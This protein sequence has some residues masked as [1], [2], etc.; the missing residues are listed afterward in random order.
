MEE[1]D[2]ADCLAKMRRGWPQAEIAAETAAEWWPTAQR[3][4]RGDCWQ[5]ID[6]LIVE[7]AFPPALAELA[8]A[9]AQKRDARHE[10]DRDVVAE[11]VAAFPI[12]RAKCDWTD[13]EVLGQ[14]MAGSVQVRERD[15]DWVARRARLQLGLPGDI[16]VERELSQRWKAVEAAMGD[17]ETG[18]AVR[19]AHREAL[20]NE[21]D[22]M[23]TLELC[24]AAL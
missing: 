12:L 1:R 21:L 13:E 14:V 10:H 2:W 23:T 16:P 24:E 3:W 11:T 22:A 9:V 19:E 6:Q 5:A 17:R 18:A 4:N 15:W 7:S 20:L 8:K